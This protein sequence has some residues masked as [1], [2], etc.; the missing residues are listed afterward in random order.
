MNDPAEA[1]TLPPICILVVDDHED[2]ARA[3][4]RLLRHH[5]HIVTSTGSVAG[6]IGLVVGQ[7][8]FDL[9]ISDISLPDGDGCQLLRRL[10]EYYGNKQLPAVALTGF[11]DENLIAECRAAGYGKFLVKPVNFD[12]VQAAIEDLQ[13]A[14]S[15][16]S[17]PTHSSATAST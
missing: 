11:S 17:P 8:P 9:L 10:R 15:C 13:T 5:G 16:M 7:R 3:L 6:A 14:T 12:D 4:A 1:T 2:S